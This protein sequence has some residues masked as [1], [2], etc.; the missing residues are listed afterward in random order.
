M[1]GFTN[2]AWGAMSLYG[3]AISQ[4]VG[5]TI[6]GTIH[7]KIVT[8]YIIKPL[9][10]EDS[11]LAKTISNTTI[12]A[13]LACL[14]LAGATAA[15]ACVG[16]V[17][18]PY[19][20]SYFASILSH[21]S[22][23]FLGSAI[24]NALGG[25]AELAD[26]H[27]IKPSL[28]HFELDGTNVEFAIGLVKNIGIMAG[29]SWVA[30]KLLNGSSFDINHKAV[31]DK[32]KGIH[33][34]QLVEKINPAITN[35]LTTASNLKDQLQDAVQGNPELTQKFNDAAAK[36]NL[37]KPAWEN[38]Q[39]S[40]DNL[41][42]A[43]QQ[44]GPIANQTLIDTKAVFESAAKVSESYAL[45]SSLKSEVD[46]GYLHLVGK[47]LGAGLSTIA[48][49][50]SYLWEGSKV[51]FPSDPDSVISTTTSG[52]ALRSVVGSGLQAFQKAEV[53]STLENQA[54]NSI[55]E[56]INQ[57]KALYPS[58]TEQEWALK[59]NKAFQDAAIKAYAHHGLRI[60][61]F[62]QEDYKAYQTYLE[63]AQMQQKM[64]MDYLAAHPEL[65]A[66]QQELAGVN[67]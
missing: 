14:S 27:I 55:S 9:G 15:A 26:K 60:G 61:D 16:P 4:F 1:S 51:L 42:I 44:A 52:I 36:L 20:L 34:L 41:I 50:F 5:S 7:E 37:A 35:Q 57:Y 38:L 40:R 8:P 56:S 43:A 30:S 65:L 6:S 31:Q 64:L 2:F 58:I 17:G 3:N 25:V 19:Y 12:S 46:G 48:L 67:A 18:A 63:Q 53:K 47:Y 62:N 59:A 32:L 28:Q 21:F 45:L 10:L 54:R 66:G 29:S 13:G 24:N 49:P 23:I 11:L 39:V 33:N 22:S